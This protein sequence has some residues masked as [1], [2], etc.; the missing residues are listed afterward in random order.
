MQKKLYRSQTDNKIA[1]LCGGL[2]EYLDIDST[3][4]RV[5]WVLF[6]CVGAGLLAYLICALI[7][8]KKPDNTIDAQ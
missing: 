1:G 6:A 5:L 4:I 3:V 7:V 2:G 8:P